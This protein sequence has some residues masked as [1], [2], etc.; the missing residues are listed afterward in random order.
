MYPT[1]VIILVAHA[2]GPALPKSSSDVDL[3]RIASL[4]RRNVQG[5]DHDAS[6]D[7]QLDS[8]I[9]LYIISDA[10]DDDNRNDEHAKVDNRPELKGPSKNAGADSECV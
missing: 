1:L 3:E 2:K 5:P 8:T 4:P 10:Q 9:S 6:S 7:C